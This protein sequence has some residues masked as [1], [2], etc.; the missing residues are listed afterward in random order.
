MFYSL[1][2]GSQL[3]NMIK[4]DPHYLD[5]RH[6]DSLYS[7]VDDIQFYLDCVEEYG[8]PTMELAC[9]TGRITIP[10]AEKGIDIT[11]LDLSEMMLKRAKDK[12]SKNDLDIDFIRSDMKDFSM[13]KNFNTI[14]LPFN[15]I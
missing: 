15:S 1:L 4:K 13:D 3:I 8:D 2:T 7:R 10:L 11:G 6:Y 9:G 14:L 5:G 12:A